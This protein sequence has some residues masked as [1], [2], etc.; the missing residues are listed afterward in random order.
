LIRFLRHAY[1]GALSRGPGYEP[2]LRGTRVDGSGTAG[3]EIDYRPK[4][5]TKL[6]YADR[7]LS[8]A[9]AAQL[10]LGW[11]EWIVLGDETA[12]VGFLEVCEELRATAVAVEAGLVWPY[13]VT[14]AK[15]PLPLPWYSGMAQGQIASVFVRA[16]KRTGDDTFAD[17]ALKAVGPLLDGYCRLVTQ[18]SR[19]P[20][21]E[22]CGPMEPPAHILNGW[23]FGL[24]GVRDVAL[25]LGDSGAARLAAQSTEALAASVRLYDTNW[26]TRYSLFPHALPD[27]AK[28][29]YHRLH[30][31]QMETMHDVSGAE[32]FASAAER[33]KAYDT[34]RA[35]VWAVASKAPFAA[36]TQIRLR[37]RE[38]GRLCTRT[39]PHA[40][41]NTPVATSD[42]EGTCVSR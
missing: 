22:E 12:E 7:P 33:W 9:G 6:Q 27:L 8:P 18:T 31:V 40:R 24:W 1:R 39:E 19:G 17:L 21:I 10:A 3:Y 35:T 28:P 30:V 38:S 29:F 25:A 16:W 4:L 34:T 20:V 13:D 15:Y 42:T 37:A 32:E 14:V 26:W 36:T 11:H 2:H 41:R 5:E 23:I